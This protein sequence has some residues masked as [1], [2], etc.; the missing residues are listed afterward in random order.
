MFNLWTIDGV[1]FLLAIQN[2]V[3]T[4]FFYFEST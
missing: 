2:C 1:K 4:F 3:N